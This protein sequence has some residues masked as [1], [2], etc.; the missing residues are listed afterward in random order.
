MNFPVWQL[1]AGVLCALASMS[2]AM[3][4]QAPR[5]EIPRVGIIDYYGLRKVS[6]ERVQKALA[7]KEGDAMP[8]SKADALDRLDEISGVVN[9]HLEAVCCDNG[10]AILFVG[11]EEKGAPHFA[12]H[13]PPAGAIQLPPEIVE[14]Y[15]K[16]LAALEAAVR[17]G[18]VAE[19]LRSGHS[20]MAD[21][22]TRAAQLRFTELAAANLPLLRDV[23]RNSSDDEHR[24]I[25]AY[26]LGYAPKKRDVVDD[27]QYA[28]QDPD[29]GVRNNSMRALGAILVLASRSKD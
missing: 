17:R 7:V 10:K 2:P 11:I 27:L 22:E 3:R 16:F 9:S 25:A 29:D 28:M 13:S 12:F 23:L 26:I 21:P 14:E 20:L 15:G 5:L 18:S 19:D 4:A 6:R 8:G 1:R 24:A